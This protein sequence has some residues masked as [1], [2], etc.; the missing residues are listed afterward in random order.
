MV[1]RQ[2]ESS[3]EST[4]ALEISN[5]SNISQISKHTWRAEPLE[6]GLLQMLHMCLLEPEARDEELLWSPA[7]DSLLCTLSTESIEF[8]LWPLGVCG[9]D[10][11]LLLLELLDELALDCF[12]R[13]LLMLLLVRKLPSVVLDDGETVV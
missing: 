11:R 4:K 7:G 9:L 12:R 13:I 3:Y 10:T 5:V 6:K 1:C 2:Y 8:E